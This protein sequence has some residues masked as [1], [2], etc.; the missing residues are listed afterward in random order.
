MSFG[1]I[2][3]FEATIAPIVT[4]LNEVKS[5]VSNTIVGQENM[6]RSILIGLLTKGH[7]LLEGLPGVA[8]TLT[9]NTV[10]DILQ[11]NF[12]RIQFTPD[13]L[14][15]DILGSQ[16]YRPSSGEF[17]IRKGPLF[18][19]IILADEINRAPAKVQS[20]MLEVMQENQ[21]TL[22]EQTHQLEMP[23]MVI[24]TQN[25]IEQE[26]TYNLPE[27]QLDR[28]FFK[29]LLDYP[30]KEEEHTILRR[31]A[32]GE[33]LEK[34]QPVL[35]RNDILEMQS[36]VDQVYLDDKIYSY[37]V[38]LVHSTRKPEDFGLDSLA[39][40][41]DIGVSP[42][43]G[44]VLAKGAK[45]VAFMDGR[46]YVQPQDVKSILKNSFRHRIKL[47]FEADAE[48]TGVDFIIEHILGAVKVL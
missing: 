36:Y 7:I 13:M 23:Y 40:L 19:N 33:K 4:K 45:A 6:V 21:I 28:F 1:K 24:A 39:T 14:P 42:R 48:E 46:G 5:E 2:R 37:I 29:V 34:S 18:S 11:V 3:D 20:A 31:Y 25:P 44:L 9:V 43:A 8:K 30:S 41:I 35:D 38:D 27:A 17:E 26:G 12:Q 22:A 16:I 32:S 47:S 15:A 10:S